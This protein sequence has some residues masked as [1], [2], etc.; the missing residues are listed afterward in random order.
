MTCLTPAVE[1]SGPGA[2]LT[3]PDLPDNLCGGAEMADR[4]CSIDGCERVVRS[5]GWC[6]M[7]Y[8]RWF[9]HGDAEKVVRPSE[10]KTRPTADRFW[11]KVDKTEGG[12]WVWLARR[13]VDGY[14]TFAMPFG[15]RWAPVRAH[16]F[17]Y[18]LLVGPI[19]D[20]LHLDHLCRNRACVNP[21]HLEPVTCRENILRGIAP[22]AINAAKTH[23]TNGHE[24]TPANTYIAPANGARLCRACRLVAA[25]KYERSVGRK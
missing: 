2:A 11:E 4:T 15:K 23:C 10:R 19:P 18:E 21:D 25:R 22:S 7:H 14:G 1:W 17:A 24:F 6:R 12:C 3:A 20:G 5:R 8:S 16:R 9:R 13:S